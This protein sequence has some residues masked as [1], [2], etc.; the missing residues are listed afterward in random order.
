MTRRHDYV[1]P[2]SYQQRQMWALDRIVADRSAYGEAWTA[3]IRGPLDLAALERAIGAIVD[4]HDTL[5]T[6]FALVDG[7][8]VQ[9]GAPRGGFARAGD[10]HEGRPPDEREAAARQ[11][12]ARSAK[13][14]V[15]LVDGPVFRAH[16]IRVARDE[17][18]LAMASHHIAFDRWS[19]SIF[20]RELAE[21]YEACAS[22]R[23]PAW[24]PLP[25]QYADY[26]EWQ[27]ERLRGGLLEA[28]LAH[29]RSALA[30]LS[31]PELPADRL[32][33][34]RPTHRGGEVSFAL[35]AACANRLRDIARAHDASLFMVLLAA[36]D[37]FL[38]R[39]CGQ[40]DIAVAVPVAGRP[41]AELEPLIGDFAN[42]VVMR[43]DLAND[44]TFDALVDAV[45]RT[46][47]DAYDHA[48][49]PFDQ[50]V[51]RLA[52]R[53]DA[54]RNPLA[55]VSFRLRNTPSTALALPGLAVERVDGVV[56]PAAKFDLAMAVD[57][58]GGT[59]AGR[60]E[61]A[62]DLFDEATIARA[63]RQWL[64]L[65]RSIAEDP[66]RRVSWLPMQDAAA[67]AAQI[68]QWRGR[69]T[70]FPDDVGVHRLVEAVARASPGATAIVDGERVT[71]YAELDARANRLARAILRRTGDAPARVGVALE[72]GTALV[73]AM[74]ATLKAGHAYV[75]IDVEW[76]VARIGA[77]IADADVALVLCAGDAA[78]HLPA[79][80][81]TLLRID[82]DGGDIDAEPPDAIARDPADPGG[83]P[84]YVIYTSGSTGRPK[85]VEVTH[86][87]IARLVRG[88]D[89]VQVVAS[90]AVANAAH[91]AFDATTFEVWGALANG[92]R[93]VVIPRLVA[94]APRALAQ[95]LRERGVSVLWLTASLFHEVARV[96]PGAFSGCRA[97][98][99]GGEPAEPRLV[100]AICEAGRPARL[101]N[102]YGP[103]E[104]TTFATWHLVGDVGPDC[105][106]IPI[107]RPIANTTAWVLDE[108]MEPVPDG[109][110]G[111]LWLGGPGL[112]TGYVGQPAL[113]AERFRPHPFDA[114]P[115]ARLYRTGDRVR[116]DARGDLLYLG[117]GDRQVKL[118]GHRIELDEIEH[119]LARAPGIRECAVVATGA[120]SEDRRIVAYAVPS[121]PDAPPP[122][123][124]RRELKRLLPD[125]M[126]PSAVVWLRSMPMND[127]GK[128]DR[129]ALPAPPDAD[130]PAAADVYVPPRD[131]LEHAIAGHVERVLGHGPV[132]IHEHFFEIGGHSLLAARLVDEIE[133]T[134]GVALPL[135]ALFADDTI[136]GL[137]ERLRSD[138][139][140][141]DAP[142]VSLNAEGTRPPLVLLHGDLTGGGFY[143]R[144][145]ARHLG[146]DQPL[147]VVQPHLL[148]RG[149]IPPTIEA[150]AEDRVRLLREARPH[151][152]YVLAGYCNGA[153]VAFE[154]ARQLAAAG[155]EVPLVLAIEA[156]A[157]S[158]DGE[159]DDAYL[160][161]DPS[162]AMRRLAATDHESE[163][164]LH[165]RRAMD[166]YV[167][168]PYGGTL[169]V[170]NSRDVKPPREAGWR[171][172]ARE[173]ELRRVDDTH[174]RIV[175]H[176][177]ADV[178]SLVGEAI[179]RVVARRAVSAG[180]GSSSSARPAASA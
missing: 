26:A 69:P 151:G 11:I 13:A 43:A 139:E 17:H 142:V 2:A 136:A 126:L 121:S 84:A 89:F 97:L 180:S 140:A 82:A 72:R 169:V 109:L 99:F 148:R 94:L 153:Y 160:T 66:S 70:P 15:D 164:R 77:V 56:P 62:A 85:G 29:W 61:Y 34:P 117:R 57:E 5:R 48:D 90:D 149:A 10:D 1:A 46:A 112:A 81:A 102:G 123:N 71:T 24:P 9:P 65:L 154:M 92:A 95:A 44:P 38:A 128:I 150:M 133:R 96:L 104:A 132:G 28:Q 158:G 98:I 73:V 59:L 161:L 124:L 93:L 116:V 141:D 122:A 88:A 60:L 55:Q 76:P 175:T 50:L 179:E 166:R 6:T 146:S 159:G 91:P 27:R 178:A 16:A 21:A 170:V 131:M 14:P 18:W 47:L 30:G 110:P 107:G 114:S 137:A 4:R 7:E 108:A 163:M 74:L 51:E 168:E 176:R 22:G 25:V 177:A 155:E 40:A 86:R 23:E 100:R 53:R 19:A 63:C 79:G 83:A 143:A 52:P 147:L 106:S 49:V 119:A 101:V 32:R 64:E 42:V 156:M 87:A 3:R 134:S 35:D 130:A 75:P 152:P 33:P 171:A 172:L 36:F 58:A 54:S 8:L 135:A 173:V 165:Y 115:G 167:P 80:E 41:R 45:R 37:V 162:G 68:E 20:A 127:S 157:P 118:R 144:T 138:V 125:V 31:P 113:T 145:L 120:T 39:W 111:E 105:V 129:R 174:V 103:T 78:R 67:R 12:A